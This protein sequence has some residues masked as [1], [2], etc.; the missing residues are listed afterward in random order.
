MSLTK[1]GRVNFRKNIRDCYWGREKTNWPIADRRV[2]SNALKN[3]WGTNLV[4]RFFWGTRFSFL[5][6]FTSRFWSGEF[7]SDARNKRCHTNA[8]VLLKRQNSRVCYRSSWRAFQIVPWEKLRC[9]QFNVFY[10]RCVGHFCQNLRKQQIKLTMQ[11]LFPQ[12]LWS[13]LIK[14]P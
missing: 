1:V 13:L 10:E 7:T 3:N 9:I 11:K 8:E 14:S 6:Q 2:F 5:P 12:T 4:P